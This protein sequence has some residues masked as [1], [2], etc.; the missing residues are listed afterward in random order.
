MS[1][2]PAPT[3]PAP[4]DAAELA[5]RQRAR[6]CVEAWLSQRH[7][8]AWLSDVY[9]LQR[10]AQ[11]HAV[12]ACKLAGPAAPHLQV[13]AKC[14]AA[15]NFRAVAQR[16]RRVQQA[17]QAAGTQVLGVPDV[18]QI[19][20]AR[21]VLL[22]A[23]AR[24]EIL[25]G[26]PT[27]D[28][29]RLNDAVARCSTA[30]LE[31]HR[32]PTT[33]TLCDPGE[34]ASPGVAA[35]PTA[36]DTQMADLMH[37]HPADLAARLAPHAPVAAG[38]LLQLVQ[39]LRLADADLADAAPCLV[40]RDGHPRQIFVGESRVDIIDWDLCGLGDPAIDLAN[41]HLHI[42]LRWP[43]LAGQLHHS[44][45]RSYG[46]G[47]P[48]HRRVPLFLAFHHLRRA[49]KAWRQAGGDTTSAGP[50]TAWLASAAA[51]L[52]DYLGGRATSHGRVP[53]SPSRG[54]RTAVRPVTDH[55][56]QPS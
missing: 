49:C 12:F 54:A 29:A 38:Q 32:L 30:L 45:T 53:A 17:I 9:T 19:D 23:P 27:N 21:Q 8:G 56:E 22:M 2:R 50:A 26:L 55:L 42:D 52:D 15:G 5:A 43:Q 33:T 16:T 36:I 10:P 31:L 40:H 34:Q 18:L 44:V 6:A 51:H 20:E 46:A 3:R 39:G 13:I 37:P 28:S 11:G 24:G 1:A 48:V 47:S 4:A 35:D 14:L 7:P 25:A 41:L